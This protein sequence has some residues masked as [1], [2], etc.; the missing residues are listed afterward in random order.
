MSTDLSNRPL[1]NTKRDRALFVNREETL[2]VV[3]ET[4][5]HRGNVLL[6]GPAGSG[7]SSLLRFLV[8]LLEDEDKERVL[9]VDGRVATSAV[10]FL[11]ILRDR[12]LADERMRRSARVPEPG[13]GVM[14]VAEETGQ[15]ALEYPRFNSQTLLVEL[16]Q[17]RASLPDGQTIVVVDETPSPGVA[18]T[19]FGRLRDE[20]WELPLTWFV[21]ADERDRGNYTEPPADAFWR[22]IVELPPLTESESEELLRRRL[23]TDGI[24]SNALTELVGEGRGNPRRLLTL[25]YEIAV[26]GRSPRQVI[27][28][29]RERERRL[30][31]LSG[32]A[33]R[34]LNELETNGPASPSDEGLLQ[35]LG[36]SRSRASQVFGELEEHGFV[37]ATAKSG[38]GTRPRRVFEATL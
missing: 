27:E 5:K 24:P 37:T 26:E 8:H 2:R 18:H 29:R 23:D 6:V 10:E 22:R 34:L 7:K 12:S 21:A 31:V 16:A 17:L 4:L 15:L 28:Q 13:P 35:R 33:Q 9:T 20:L 36:W 30:E 38:T 19:L 11:A 25:A 14:T 3:R 1:R 32:P